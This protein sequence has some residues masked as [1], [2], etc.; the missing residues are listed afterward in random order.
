MK[1]RSFRLNYMVFMLGILLLGCTEK[2]ASKRQNEINRLVFATGGCYGTCPIQVID[3]DSSLLVKYH[4]IQYSNLDGFYNGITTREFWDSLN[5]KFE[6]INYKQL[7]SIYVHTVDDLSTELMIYDNNN[8]IK[9]IRAQSSSLP[10]SIKDVYNWILK[11]ITQMS[12]TKTNDSLSF[13][14]YL[15]RPPIRTVIKF[16]PPKVNEKH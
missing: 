4:G 10:D 8:R 7:D 12:L 6:N 9:Y 3:I 15:N 5:I 2:K 1:L 16:L 14:T 13:P 11:S